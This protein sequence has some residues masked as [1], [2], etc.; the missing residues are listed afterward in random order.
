MHDDPAY[1]WTLQ[2]LA[3]RAG[4]PRSTFGRK[5][6]RTVGASPIEYLTRWRMLLAGD[7]LVNSSD[8]VST[9]TLSLGYKSETAFVTPSEGSWAVRHGN[10]P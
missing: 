5:F 4:M 10:K 1:R 9:I 3:E 8:P 6:K 2:E 7:T